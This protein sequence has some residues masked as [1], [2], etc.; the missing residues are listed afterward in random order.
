MTRKEMSSQ[1]YRIEQY[2]RT[3]RMLL[4][5]GQHPIGSLEE[6]A[7]RDLTWAVQACISLD[8]ELK[9]AAVQS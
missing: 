6:R 1:L 3:A 5:T 8:R 4:E 2:I 9:L 7:A